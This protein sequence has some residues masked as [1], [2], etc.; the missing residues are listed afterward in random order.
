MPDTLAELCDALDRSD[1]RSSLMVKA[2][3]A[4]RRRLV[5]A[6]IRREPHTYRAVFERFRLDDLGISFTAFYYWARKVRRSA[7]LTELARSCADEED[8][9]DLVIKVLAQRLLDASLDEDISINTLTHLTR[10]YRMASSVQL[11]RRR[12]QINARTV[13]HK[14]RNAEIDE[15]RRLVDR[16]VS[17]KKNA[18]HERFHGLK[19]PPP[20]SDDTPPDVAPT[21]KDPA[22]A[23][24]PENTP[25]SAPSDQ[26]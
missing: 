13:A 15:I 19:E 7:A 10:A 11:A 12:L 5:D 24:L 9:A 22:A 3:P 26:R 2:H 1:S 6:I 20:I 16:Y 14:Q 8:P 4:I 21:T 23:E 25:L 18:P 17:T